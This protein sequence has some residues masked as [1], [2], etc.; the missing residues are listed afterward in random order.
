MNAL[1]EK[2][3]AEIARLPEPAQETIASLIVDAI[4]ADREWD[5]R[6]AKS[7]DQLGELVRRARSEAAQGDVLA[8]PPHPS[9]E[10]RLRRRR[11]AGPRRGGAA[12]GI[13]R[14]SRRA[15]RRRAASWFKASTPTEKAIAA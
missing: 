4:E 14:L 5:G 1:L 2:A 6:F 10:T 9:Q 8:A 15:L 12:P 7:Q 11:P 13:G 3:F